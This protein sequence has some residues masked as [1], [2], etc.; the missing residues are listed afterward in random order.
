MSADHDSFHREVW[1]TKVQNLPNRFS[2]CWFLCCYYTNSNRKTEPVKHSKI[3]PWESPVLE[4]FSIHGTYCVSFVF[5]TTALKVSILVFNTFLHS[6]KKNPFWYALKLYFFP[7]HIYLT[8]TDPRWVGAWWLGF[9]VASC[10]VFITA[11][12]YFFFPRSMP[13]EVGINKLTEN[14]SKLWQ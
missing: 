9:L 3:G 1:G 7:D 8:L 4:A 11:L 6:W 14:W 2:F 5:F 12:P 13:K 10:L